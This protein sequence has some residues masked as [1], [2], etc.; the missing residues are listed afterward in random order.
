M[1]SVAASSHCMPLRLGPAAPDAE[2][3]TVTQRPVQAA[4]PHGAAAADLLGPI[5]HRPRGVLGEEHLKVG[6]HARGA[7]APVHRLGSLAISQS[8]PATWRSRNLLLTH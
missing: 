4:R 1:D 5:D 7:R 3:G 2:D 8:E 6:V